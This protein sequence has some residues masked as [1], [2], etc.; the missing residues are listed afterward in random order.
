MPEIQPNEEQKIALQDAV[1]NIY[2][3]LNVLMNNIDLHFGKIAIYT[4]LSRVTEYKTSFYGENGWFWRLPT[5]NLAYGKFEDCRKKMVK[6]QNDEDNPITQS[7]VA[8][9][10]TCMDDMEKYKKICE[11]IPVKDESMIGRAMKFT[12]LKSKLDSLK[13]LAS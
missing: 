6:I 13:D 9:C 12:G 10:D 5:W 8:Q 7:L 4:T 11:G 1:D 3:H 2:S